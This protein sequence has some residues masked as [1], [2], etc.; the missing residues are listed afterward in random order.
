MQLSRSSI[1]GC[2]LS[3]RAAGALVSCCLHSATDERVLGAAPLPG[4]Q[5]R[6]ATPSPQ[7]T[8]T[9]ATYAFPIPLYSGP[10]RL[11]VAEAAE[12]CTDD[13]LALRIWSG[14]KGRKAEGRASRGSQGTRQHEW[15]RSGGTARERAAASYECRQ[16]HWVEMVRCVLNERALLP[17]CG[18]RLWYTY[19]APAPEHADLGAG[20]S[21]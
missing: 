17:P 9:A 13:M 1:E 20:L 11:E 2:P 5:A 18:F 14:S 8:R 3:G 10:E 12:V 7:Y 16:P 6:T 15:S 4:C 21:I 19:S